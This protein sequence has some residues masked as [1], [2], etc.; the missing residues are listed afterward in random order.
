MAVSFEAAAK[1]L[2]AET[3]FSGSEQ[4]QGRPRVVGTAQ[5]TVGPT[6]CIVLFAWLTFSAAEVEA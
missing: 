6:P 3:S 2:T 1:M 4:Q 5:F